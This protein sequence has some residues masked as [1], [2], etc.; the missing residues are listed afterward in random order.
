[1]QVS[2]VLRV[3]ISKPVGRSVGKRVAK[4]GRRVPGL[5]IVRPSANTDT[6]FANAS[7]NRPRRRKMK[8]ANLLHL[9]R[10]FCQHC[11][12]FSSNSLSLPPPV[13]PLSYAQKRTGSGVPT[14]VPEPVVLLGVP[15]HPHSSLGDCMSTVKSDIRSGRQRGVA[16]PRRLERKGIEPSTSAL[17]TPR[18]SHRFIARPGPPRRQR[19]FTAVFLLHRAL[20]HPSYAD[21]RAGFNTDAPTRRSQCVQFRSQIS[22]TACYRSIRPAGTR[23]RPS[24]GSSR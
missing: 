17:R 22:S 5:S 19:D 18:G 4:G 21:L 13:I 9:P 3:L 20:H 10:P 16:S 12:H 1:M 15:P 11:Q 7:A 24:A 23:S 2:P 14:K 8:N 6:P